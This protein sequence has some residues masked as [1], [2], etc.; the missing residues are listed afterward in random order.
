MKSLTHM[1][2]ESRRVAVTVSDAPSFRA[3]EMNLP[4]SPTREMLCDPADL[5]ACFVDELPEKRGPVF[6]GCDIG[7][8]TSGTAWA[9]IWPVTGRVELRLAFGDVPPLADRAKHDAAPY[10]RMRDTG[11]LVTYPGRVTPVQAFL[12][13]SGR[14]DGGRACRTARER[15]G[16]RILNPATFSSG[17]RFDGLLSFG[18][19]ERERMVGAMCGRRNG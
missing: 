19:S 9:A 5:A 3:L 18:A 8:A 16:T 13:D 12:A 15:R 2:A 4:Q 1:R 10:L 17:P 14:G 6:V 7:E 11:E